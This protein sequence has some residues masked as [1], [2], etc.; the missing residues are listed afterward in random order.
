MTAAAE[1]ERI[2]RARRKAG[3]RVYSFTADEIWLEIM[4]EE[5]EFL[6]PTICDRSRK[7]VLAAL[8]ALIDALVSDAA[9]VTR[10]GPGNSDALG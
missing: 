7:E 9:S 4:L 3:L 10:H 6:A 1:R 8:Q 5:A 2:R